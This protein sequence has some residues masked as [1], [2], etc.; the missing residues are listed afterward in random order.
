MVVDGLIMENIFPM[1]ICVHRNEGENMKL[2]MYL[3]IHSQGS[4]SWK[5]VG[6]NPVKRYRGLDRVYDDD[7]VGLPD[8]R[9]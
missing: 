7:D 8:F 3:H 1:S 4:D 6:C 2:A 5:P 9:F